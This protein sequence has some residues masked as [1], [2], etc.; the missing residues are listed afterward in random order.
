MRLNTILPVLFGCRLEWR[1]MVRRKSN[2]H[3]KDYLCYPHTWN[4][5]AGASNPKVCD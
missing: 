5:F 1:H 4:Y 2:S 3:R